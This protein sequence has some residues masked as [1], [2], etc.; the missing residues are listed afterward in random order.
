[1]YEND[2]HYLNTTSGEIF[3]KISGTWNSIG[4]LSGP[5]GPQGDDGDD[6]NNIT[7]QK[8]G[9]DIMNN[10]AIMNFTGDVTTTT[11]SGSK[12][13]IAISSKNICFIY[14]HNSSI[15]V[16]NSTPVALPFDEQQIIDSIYT[17][18]KTTNN[19]RIEV[20]ITG[21]YKLIYAVNYDGSS[22]RRNVHSYIRSNGSN[23]LILTSCYAYSRNSNDDKATNSIETIIHLDSGTY[24]E[25]MNVREGTSGTAYSITNECW[26]ILELMR[27][28]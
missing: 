7:V 6:G 27:E 19:S 25:L 28:G 22:N 4:N 21:W 11:S 5:Q 9:T 1:M 23:N 14:N 13:N 26:L 8:D 24:I 3:K 16:N 15:N 12:V 20:S 17:H 10:V 18:N 2:D